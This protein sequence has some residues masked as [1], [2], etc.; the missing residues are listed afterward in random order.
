MNTNTSSSK[1]ASRVDIL[2]V[3]DSPNLRRTMQLWFE[4]Q[5]YAT[6]TAE[7]AAEAEQ[8]A[9][10]TP[11]EVVIADLGLPDRSGYELLEA[12]RQLDTLRRTHFVALS[13]DTDGQEKAHALEA[14]FDCF[15]AK[16]PDFDELSELL[17][18]CLRG[19]TGDEPTA[20]N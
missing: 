18:T 3:D 17:E 10:A 9:A 15:I 13:G 5:G 8:V 12:L 11:P 16:P 4:T 20:A 19:R 7:S 14:G 2:F 6:C 1:S